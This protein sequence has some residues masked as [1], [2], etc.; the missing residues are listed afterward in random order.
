MRLSIRRSDSG[1]QNYLLSRS[2]LQRTIITL[3]G[4]QQTGCIT[5]DDEANVV[6]RFKHPMEFDRERQELVDEVVHG[7][8]AIEFIDEAV[9]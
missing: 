4:V 1:F 8:V 3:D 5:A 9:L 2:R 7:R 6:V